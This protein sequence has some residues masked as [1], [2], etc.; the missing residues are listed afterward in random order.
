MSEEIDQWTPALGQE[1]I[2]ETVATETVGFYLEKGFMAPHGGRADGFRLEPHSPGDKY[3][4]MHSTSPKTG[5]H[6]ELLAQKMDRQGEHTVAATLRDIAGVNS[7]LLLAGQRVL[8]KLD[9]EYESVNVL[10]QIELEKAVG[11]ANLVLGAN[12]EPG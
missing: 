11:Y 8:A 5:S 12:N 7:Q 1:C 4:P 6:I 2:R 10:D 3:R 9:S